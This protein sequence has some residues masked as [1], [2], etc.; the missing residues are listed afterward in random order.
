RHTALIK[1]HPQFKQWVMVH[2]CSR[3]YGILMRSDHQHL[4][5]DLKESLALRYRWV[6]R[7]PGAGARH[8]FDNWLT[9]M[10]RTSTDLNVVTTAYSERELAGMIAR[11]EA[12]FGMGC[13]GIAGEFGLTFIPLG[14]ESFDLVMPQGVYF[15]Y[16][17]QQL[18]E[19]MQTPDTQAFAQK[20]GGY[21]L[22]GCGKIIWSPN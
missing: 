20:L 7:Q 13:Q 3:D 22:S 4:C 21:D 16:L 2:C 12:E 8:H 6:T 14:K 19:L 17:L 10:Q 9:Q 5:N 15:R 18:F 1:R 11:G